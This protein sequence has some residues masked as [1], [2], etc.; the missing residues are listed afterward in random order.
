MKRTLLLLFLCA[1]FYG[2]AQEVNRIAK[3]YY[4]SNP[5]ITPFSSF[6]EHLVNDPTLENKKIHKRTDST[7]FFFEGD[8]RTHRPFGIPD[9]YRTHVVLTEIEVEAS[10]SGRSVVRTVY[11]Y[12]L[13]GYSAA[14]DKGMKEV[15]KVFDR[16]TRKSEDDFAHKDYKELTRDGK[17]VGEI[18]NFQLYPYLN[19]D[20]VTI[21]WA[22]G[23]NGDNLFALT[24][25]F[26]VSDNWGRVP[27]LP[28]LLSD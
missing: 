3:A 17:Q 16:F 27:Y 1:S 9:S 13:V 21:A 18:N 24:I 4:R 10:D 8:Y 22:N 12:Q 25:R 14:G 28:G 6:L 2:H 7:L 5:F 11:V 26:I 20:H 19:F 23:Q 15:K